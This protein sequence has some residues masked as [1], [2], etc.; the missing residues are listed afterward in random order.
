[1]ISVEVL[2]LTCFI[3]FVFF[4][5]VKREN[6]LFTS[7]IIS[8]MTASAAVPTEGDRGR[9]N[10]PDVAEGLRRSKDKRK[11]SF[12]DGGAG[13]AARP[14]RYHPDCIPRS[15]KAT[16]MGKADL[17]RDLCVF[18]TLVGIVISFIVTTLS[19]IGLPPEDRNRSGAGLAMK[20][21]KLDIIA[22]SLERSATEVSNA[23]GDMAH[24]ALSEIVPAYRRPSTD[25]S[26]Y[27]A[28]SSVVGGGLGLFAGVRPF[29]SADV[30]PGVRPGPELPLSFL[31]GAGSDRAADGFGGGGREEFFSPIWLTMRTH[32][33]LANVR[34]REGGG[35]GDGES[36][37]RPAGAAAY[38][39]SREI[40]PGEELFMEPSDAPPEIGSAV[41]RL[42]P[43]LPDVRAYAAADAV[44]GDMLLSLPRSAGA[45]ARG[46]AR[47][48]IKGVISGES[49]LP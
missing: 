20:K 42:F 22:L 32:P 4:V 9:A 23:V 31:S 7:H 12:S 46:K 24:R 41:S 13:A 15:Q 10:L 36:D 2:V 6:K 27:L 33:I 44:A 37:P 21:S 18:L 25:C 47:S 29:G 11:V 38:V 35:G 8:T 28:E 1:M 17:K 39:A 34:A 19:E 49:A 16:L 30:V 5:R 43:D 40:G 26:A 14:I 48:R 3:F 45:V